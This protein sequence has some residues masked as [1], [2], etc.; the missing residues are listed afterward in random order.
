MAK[1]DKQKEP[2]FGEKIKAFFLFLFSKTLW[3]N[4]LLM[5]VTAVVIVI[6]LHQGLKLYTR[7]GQQIPLPD[8][9]G[10]NIESA[11]EDA[12][13]RSFRMF[14][15]DSI[16]IVGRQGGIIIDQVPKAH[17]LVKENRKIYVTVTKNQP[18]MVTLDELPPLYGRS[19][20]RT[21]RV[22]QMAHSI[23]SNIAGRTF[24]PG[25]EG[26]IM[27]VIYQGDTIIDRGEVLR[28]MKVPVGGRIDFI[29]SEQR[30]G[31]VEIPD[32]VCRT[33][34]EAE[35]IIRS[36]RL[37]IGNTRLQGEIE[38]LQRAFI[39]EQDPPFD[40]TVK[41]QMGSSVNLVLSAEKPQFCDPEFSEF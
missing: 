11:T 20:E 25:P 3:V 19:F 15:S 38:D 36:Y 10:E 27:G 32:L 7:H 8:Y 21:A 41:V 2:D 28:D 13:R 31:Q 6:L 26:H 9:V 33:F 17:E 4:L 24:D 29:I 22:L 16:F 39:V 37:R 5:A 18:D 35:F 34:D 1:K 30:G 40:E 12:E 14:V 23:E